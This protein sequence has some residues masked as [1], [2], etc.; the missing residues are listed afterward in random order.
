VSKNTKILAL[1]EKPES[2]SYKI[3]KENSSGAGVKN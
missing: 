1:R 2:K 3:L